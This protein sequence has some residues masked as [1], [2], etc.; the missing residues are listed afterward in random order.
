[1]PKTKFILT[2]SMLPFL[3]DNGTKVKRNILNVYQIG[4][5]LFFS[6]KKF[7]TEQNYENAP[8]TILQEKHFRAINNNITERR[9]PDDAD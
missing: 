8:T 4:R 9:Y 2:P 7:I 1:M 5:F 3:R 6:Q